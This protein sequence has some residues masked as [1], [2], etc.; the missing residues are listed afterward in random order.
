MHY[1][2]GSDVL[3]DVADSDYFADASDMMAAGDMIMV[4]GAH[5]CRVLSIAEA[6]AGTVLSAPLL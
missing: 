5:G 3:A 4:S 1:K 2:A 6:D